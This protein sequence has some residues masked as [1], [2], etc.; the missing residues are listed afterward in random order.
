MDKETQAKLEGLAVA[1]GLAALVAIL[2]YL[3]DNLP[4]FFP[5]A[6]WLPVAGVAI[7]AILAVISQNQRWLNTP[8][9]DHISAPSVAGVLTAVAPAVEQAIVAAATPPP[10]SPPAP[11]VKP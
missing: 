4:A 7:A 10:A 5:G 11:V 6:T 8:S 9:K 1:A 3:R 2:Q